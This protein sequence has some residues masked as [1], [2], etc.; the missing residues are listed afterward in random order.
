MKSDIQFGNRIE[1]RITYVSREFKIFKQTEK[2]VYVLSISGKPLMSCSNSIGRILLKEN[3]ARVKS[4]LPFVIQL[5]YVTT[6]YTQPLT[7]GV[8]TGSDKIGSAVVKDNGDVVYLAE[9]KIHNDI[10]RKMKQR[11]K[12]R[13]SRRFRKTRYRQARWLNRKNSIKKDRFSPTMISKFHSHDKEI[14]YVKSI[15]PI[16]KLILE[17]ATFDAHALKN[18]EVRENKVLYQQGLNYGFANTKAYV[19]DRDN[20][21]CQNC[22]AKKVGLQVHHIVY[23]SNG[24]SDEASN[25]ITL[26]GVCHDNVHNNSLVLNVRG[27]LKSNLK[28]ATQ[29]NS[30]RKQMLRRYPKAIET[31]GFE[32][33]EHRQ[34][35]GLS[36]EHYNDA[37][38]IASEGRRIELKTNEVFIKRAVTRGDY[39]FRYGI[40]S[41][42]NIPMG[43][44][45]GFRKFDKVKYNRQMYFIKGRR[46]RG[47]CELMDINGTK[48][49]LNP[50][51]KFEKMERVQARTSLLIDVKQIN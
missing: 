38:S 9:I 45:H 46:S 28:H 8:D 30:I 50:I 17:T 37:I 29:M 11:S 15:L 5:N 13:R 48:V 2:M 47:D 39:K 32:T 25:L 41:E 20:Y 12:Y 31:F 14:N 1:L 33:K 35:Q 18:P 7:H 4:K 51:P 21:C 10:A 49:Y 3:K 27:K 23:R 44:I 43:K 26:C 42:K 6:E 24:G 16:S 40:R 19:L 36:K 22:K 34:L